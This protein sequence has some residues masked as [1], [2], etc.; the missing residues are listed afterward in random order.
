[1]LE[2]GVAEAQMEAA[3]KITKIF[4]KPVV[5]AAMGVFSSVFFGLL[6]SLILGI[7][8]KKEGD[9]AAPA[10]QTESAE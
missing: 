3:M 10:P 4:M 8:L 5:M 6:V 1:M 2:Q 7:F 9:P